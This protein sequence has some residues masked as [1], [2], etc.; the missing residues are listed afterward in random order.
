[1]VT[2]VRLTYQDYANTSEDERY[3][4]IG[5]ELI[6][7]ESPII[8]HQ[9]N[10]SELGYYVKRFVKLN[11]LGYVLSSATDVVLSD[12]DV[13]QPDLLFISKERTHILTYANIQGAP[14]L[15][16]EIL[17][18]S[19]A[20][21]DWGVKREL[22]AKHGVKEYWIADPANKI[23]WVMPLRNGILEVQQTCHSGDTISSSVLAGFT[24]KVDDIFA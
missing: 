2:A 11:D 19:T 18:P 10:Q 14:D 9:L 21:R 5:G 20:R 17:S 16:V 24:V 4:L 8:V 3:E 22:Y 23:V 1:M 6:M 15:M 13:V 12:T 7:S